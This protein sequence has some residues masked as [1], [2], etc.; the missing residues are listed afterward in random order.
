[1]HSNKEFAAVLFDMDGTILR[2]IGIAECIWAGWA[3]SHG[4]DPAVL[5]PTIHGV[6]AVETISRLD[7]PGI[8]AEAEAERITQAEIA[9]MDGIEP[10]PGVAAF[11]GSL[12][13]DRWVVV[14]SAPRALAERRIEAAGLPMPA[15]LIAAEDVTVGKPAPDGYLLAATP[16][17]HDDRR[18]GSVQP[19]SLRAMQARDYEVALSELEAGRNQ[20]HW[21]W[22][23]LPQLRGLGASQMAQTYGM[24][25]LQARR[26]RASAN[27][28]SSLIGIDQLLHRRNRNRAYRLR[29]CETVVACHLRGG[30]FRRHGSISAPTAAGHC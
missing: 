15:I 3:E 22:Y 20:T 24:P 16:R 8:D 19:R 2:S 21:I 1:M 30:W 10:I 18:T 14:T 26:R 27:A 4:I 11:I 17:R 25:L 6:R 12:P 23:V 28:L 5:L 29:S 7:L 13:T 9:A